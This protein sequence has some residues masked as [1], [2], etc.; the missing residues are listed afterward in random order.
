ME[1]GE[2]VDSLINWLIPLNPYKIEKKQLLIQYQ[3]N[4]EKNYAFYTHAKKTAHV[5]LEW[6]IL[7]LFVCRNQ[8]ATR[9]LTFN[10]AKKPLHN[11]STIT[12]THEI[13]LLISH[14]VRT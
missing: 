10:G 9:N 1:N 13:K 14:L 3:Q 4:A 6:F 2:V 8:F 11:S 5:C 7:R 12:P